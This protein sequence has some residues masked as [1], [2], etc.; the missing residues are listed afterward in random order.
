MKKHLIWLFLA[1][2]ICLLPAAALALDMEDLEW[3]DI[4]FWDEETDAADLGLAEDEHLPLFAAHF[5]EAFP[6]EPIP[7]GESFMIHGTLQAQTWAMVETEDGRDG[8]IQIDPSTCELPNDDDLEIDRMLCWVTRETGV[9][10]GLGNQVLCTL[11]EGDTVIV[12]FAGEKT[13]Y[14]ETEVNGQ[15]AWLFTD[16]DALQEAELELVESDGITY[17][18]RI[19]EGVT[20]LGDVSVWEWGYL[21]DED[22]PVEKWWYES[23]RTVI[24]PGDI[25]E[26][27]IDLNSLVGYGK[28]ARLILPDSLRML[29]GEAIVYGSLDELRLPEGIEI[30]D[31]DAIYGTDIGRLVIPAGY[32]GEI[33][34]GDRVTI[35]RFEV[36]EGNP[37][38]RD[39]DGVLFSAD[40]KTLIRYPYRWDETH[41][42]VPAGTEVIG[43]GAFSSDWMDRPL[44][45]I[46]LPIGLK[47][48]ESYAFGGCGRLQSLTVPLTVT[49]IAD[50]AF[51]ACVSLERLSLPPGLS[52]R[53]Y[54]YAEQADFTW[55]N[56]DNG[57]TERNEERRTSFRYYTA[58]VVSPSGEETVPLWRDKTR[59][60]HVDDVPVDTRTRVTAT[61]GDMA[62]VVIEI[63]YETPAGKDWRWGD[64]VYWIALD[65]LLADTTGNTLF[66]LTGAVNNATGE[67]YSEYDVEITNGKAYVDIQD[68]YDPEEYEW[69]YREEEFTPDEITLLRTGDSSR[70]LAYLCSPDNSPIPV[71]DA[72]G[73]DEIG[74]VWDCE[75]AI[76]LEQRD[77]WAYVR[78]IRMTGW[79]EEE[80]VWVVEAE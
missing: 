3:L 68:H 18:V 16:T 37:R 39:I 46:S 60:Y 36:E 43:S 64:T 34:Y 71:L 69:V 51:Y 30:C 6:L 23:C 31:Y 21:V 41:Y 45:T 67:R 77:G 52:A 59:A 14:V 38:Y 20:I 65:C 24:R 53:W 19:C 10:A 49:E 15:I 61:E 50:S 22:D 58:R 26:Y 17:T 42:D 4:Y 2:A 5:E 66:E 44:K 12:M 63:R 29:G 40:G 57:A 80:M 25:V 47:R 28:T 32:T 27:G 9:P 55:Y 33:P 74:Q 73:G 54:G 1:L 11:Q 72:P 76:V 62:R 8:W 13:A 35:G 70:T 56:G 79:V 48:I 7:A 75:Q 78:T